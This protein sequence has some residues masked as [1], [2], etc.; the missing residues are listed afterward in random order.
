MVDERAFA[1]GGGMAS[2]RRPRSVGPIQRAYDLYGCTLGIVSRDATL[3]AFLDPILGPLIC[4]PPT[5]RDWT[6][7]LVAVE[8]VDVPTDGS[9]VFEGELH[10]GLPAVIIEHGGRRSLIATGHFSV[11][12]N[13]TARLAELRYVNDRAGAL[14]GTASFWM[15]EYILAT[16]AQYVLHGASVVDPRSDE[17]VV[18]FAP[19]GTGKT[20]TALAIAR[21]GFQLA[22]DDALVLSVRDNVPYIWGIPRQLKIS[23]QTASLLPWLGP[24]LT[25]NWIDGE[26]TVVRDALASLITLS[27]PHPR[28]VGQVLVLLPPNDRDHVL[29][30]IAKPD[31]LITIARDNVRLAPGGVA[32]ENATVFAALSMLIAAAPVAALSPGPDLSTLAPQIFGL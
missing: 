8:A 19:S 6:I 16:H 27:S 3:A 10:A 14:G 24:C 26:Q 9:L 2:D 21:S 25:K 4:D 28:R 30:P 23:Q 12:L 18:L 11:S 7:S 5:I 20:T 13:P 32:P 29:M 1:D 22:S 17:I 31:A 15:L